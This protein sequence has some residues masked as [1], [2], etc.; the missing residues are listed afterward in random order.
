MASRMLAEL[1]WPV[2]EMHSPPSLPPSLLVCEGSTHMDSFA[3][4]S[5]IDSQ[6]Q[7]NVHVK[8]TL[9]TAVLGT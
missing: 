8:E 7:S 3:L 9:E 4:S 2:P 6:K 1:R 5:P